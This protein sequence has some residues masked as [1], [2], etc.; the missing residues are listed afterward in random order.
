MKGSKHAKTLA[1]I[2]VTKFFVSEIS[3]GMFYPNV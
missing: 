3:G 1:K 2:Q